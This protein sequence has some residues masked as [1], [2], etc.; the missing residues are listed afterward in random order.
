MNDKWYSDFL[1]KH[2]R[3]WGL[4]VP[5]NPPLITDKTSPYPQPAVIEELT[6][7]GDPSYHY[8]DDQAAGT[9]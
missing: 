3:K 6:W 1:H 7:T 4:Q 5:D 8:T 9:Q 2:A